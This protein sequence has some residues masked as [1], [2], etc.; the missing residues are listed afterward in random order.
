VGT[1]GKEKALYT[2][3]DSVGAVLARDSKG[4]LY[5]NAGDKATGF[6]EVFELDPA[7][8]YTV[9]YNFTGGADG[10]GSSGVVLGPGGDLYG[11]AGPGSAGYGLVFRLRPSGS[12]TVLHTF[13]GG[14]GSQPTGAIIF[15][16]AGNLYG[17]TNEGVLGAG[18]IYKM[19]P[20][21]D[22]SVLYSF[23]G[24]ANGGNPQAGVILDSAGNLYGTAVNYGVTKRWQRGRGRRIRTGCGRQLQRAVWL[25]RW[26]RRCEPAGCGPDP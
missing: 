15:D 3:T 23:P 10:D 5:G 4:N 6:G 18:V 24:G 14:D 17:T 8:D 21:G 13:T 2:F 9:L 25:H 22:F 16:S 7:G 19:S 11:V 20:A 26:G 12:F 1:S